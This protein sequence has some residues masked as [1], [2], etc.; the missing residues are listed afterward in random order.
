MW[1]DF[2]VYVMASRRRH[3]QPASVLYGRGE[4]GGDAFCGSSDLNSHRSKG[5]PG[6]SKRISPSFSIDADP[7]DSGACRA[8]SMSRTKST[9]TDS[10]NRLPSTG[11][12]IWIRLEND[13]AGREEQPPAAKAELLSAVCGTTEVVPFP[14]PK[15]VAVLSGL[16]RVQAQVNCPTCDYQDHGSRNRA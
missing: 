9:T 13:A 10:S 8:I 7:D 11:R 6:R 2:Q 15:V 16:D 3:F 14:D 1:L 4:H 5:P 12:Q